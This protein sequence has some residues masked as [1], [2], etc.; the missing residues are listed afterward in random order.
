MIENARKL[1]CG[2]CGEELVRVYQAK[3]RLLAE[4]ASCAAKTVIRCL[5]AKL[6]MNFADD[7][8]GMLC[9]MGGD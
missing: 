7:S 9:D 8:D 3:D 4:C 6:D 1:S 5:P 2:A